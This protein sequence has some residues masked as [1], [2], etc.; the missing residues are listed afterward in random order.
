M[1]PQVFN[2]ISLYSDSTKDLET[3][4]GFLY[5]KKLVTLQA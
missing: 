3:I 5:S 1:I 2:F 4:I